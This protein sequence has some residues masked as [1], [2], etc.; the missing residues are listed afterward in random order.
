MYGISERFMYELG[1]DGNE[2]SNPQLKL[3]KCT[4]RPCVPCS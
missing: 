1:V 2:G 4:K 3:N